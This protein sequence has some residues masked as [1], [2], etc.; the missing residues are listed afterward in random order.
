MSLKGHLHCL[1]ARTGKVLWSKDTARE[2]GATGGR[3]GFACHPVVDGDRV[4]VELGAR[5]GTV[6]AFD[7]TTGKVL[8]QAGNHR[9]G[10]SSPVIHE[11]DGTRSLV[12]FTGSALAAMEPGSGRERWQFP[13]KNQ[14]EC[15]I[16][17]P[18]VSGDRIFISS[19]YYDRGATLLS[20][21]SG[22]PEV[23]WS[24][25]GMQNHCTSCVLYD[26]HLYGFDG[27]VDV[28]GG[29]GTLKCVDFGTGRVRWSKKGFGTGGVMVADGKLIIQGD[30]GDLAVAEASP[31]G[32]KLI[33]H[34]RVLDGRCWNMPVLAN[35]RIYCRSWEGELVC[36]DVSRK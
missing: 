29:K 8:W 20:V 35:G 15:N 18:V 12:V 33:S 3:H 4:F 36:L 28:K 25:K 13:T 2:L 21:A 17:T 14:Y 31:R 27:W 34:A 6:V 24:T 9:V 23:V 22:R 5:G 19:V 1:D 26:G 32:F 30:R 10:H 11:H 7:K 16:A